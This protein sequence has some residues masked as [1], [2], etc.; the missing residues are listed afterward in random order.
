MRGKKAKALWAMKAAKDR[1]EEHCD[2]AR[3]ED[4][5]LVGYDR[6][7]TSKEMIGKK[8]MSFGKK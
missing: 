2:P 5:P 8:C 3:K 4:L 6:K 1:G 7:S